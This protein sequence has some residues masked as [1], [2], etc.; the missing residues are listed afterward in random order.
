MPSRVHVPVVLLKKQTLIPSNSGASALT[1]SFVIRLFFF[2]LIKVDFNNFL[3]LH[4]PITPAVMDTNY[5]LNSLLVTYD[6]ALSA[7]CC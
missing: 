5:L 4:L 6:I 3:V 1:L 2:G 7:S